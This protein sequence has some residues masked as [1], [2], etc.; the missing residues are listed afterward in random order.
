VTITTNFPG[1]N[2]DVLETKENII[3]VKPQFRDT[4]GEWFYWAF[5]V[6][7]AA[8]KTL[9]FDFGPYAYVGYHGP[10]ISG[11]L[12]EWRWAG[13]N[14]EDLSSFVYTFG[15]NENNIYFAHDMLYGEKRLDSFAKKMK[16]DKRRLCTSEKG[17]YVPFI[18][19]GDGENVIMLTAR[20]HC[21]ESTGSYMLEGVLEELCKNPIENFRV[22][23]V[24]FVDFDGVID[25]DQGKNRR[26]HDHNRD[27]GEKTTPIYTCV[28]EI[29]NIVE[30]QQI[31]Y[32]FDF[33]SPWHL[34]GRNDKLFLVRK[35]PEKISRY[36]SFGEILQRKTGDA[37]SMKYSLSDDIN[38]GEEWNT[39]QNGMN[40]S[41]S[42]YCSKK[43]ENVLAISIETPYFGLE[44][45]IVSQQKL[46]HTGRAFARALDEYIKGENNK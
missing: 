1:G 21:C 26:P 22:I 32:A 8:G 31:K 6:S 43:P 18:Q 44:S 16:L 33:H 30:K 9:R 13:R 25:G 38:P 14:S 10:A 5:C 15:E 37:K 11:D 46:A 24:P 4:E 27:Y 34:G 23:A 12:K 7:G 20:H 2:I 39:A 41:F 42:A 19:Y 36:I 45:D 29:K 40:N 35:D 17:R 28:R 3:K